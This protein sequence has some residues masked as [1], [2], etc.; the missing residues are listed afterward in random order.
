MVVGFIGESMKQPKF[1][2]IIPA[3]N[4]ASTLAH[5][6][7]SVLLQ[8][9]PAFEIIVIDDGSTDNTKEVI[10]NSMKKSSMSFKQMLVFPAHVIMVQVSPQ[11]TG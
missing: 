8:S 7:D 5:A 4:S 6:I 1:S 11:E 2:V 9:Y 10:A 3:Y